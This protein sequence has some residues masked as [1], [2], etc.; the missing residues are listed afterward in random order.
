M[1]KWWK[2]AHI[3]RRTYLLKEYQNLQLNE[4]EFLMILMIDFLLSTKLDCQVE[5][6]AVLL[7]SDQKEVVGLLSSLVDRGWIAMEVTNKRISYS[8]DPVF[9]KKPIV[10]ISQTLFD[11]FEEQFARPLTSNEMK[12]L[13]NWMQI[14]DQDLIAWGLR[15]AVIYKKYSFSYIDKILNQWHLNGTTAEMLNHGKK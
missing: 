12:R 5:D 14:Y 1:D 13:S 3:D 9:Q 8:L 10:Q 2:E 11:L 15:Q 7:K 4:R 6:L